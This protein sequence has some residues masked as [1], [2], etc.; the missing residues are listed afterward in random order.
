MTIDETVWRE[1]PEPEFF[2]AIGK[3]DVTPEPVGGYD[4]ATGYVSQWM[5]RHGG[6]VGLSDGGTHLMGPRFFI[7][8]R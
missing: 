1:V 4:D 7:R 2:A 6:C 8:S 3:L 5:L